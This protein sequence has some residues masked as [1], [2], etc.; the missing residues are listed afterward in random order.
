MAIKSIESLFDAFRMFAERIAN[1]KSTVILEISDANLLR[2]GILHVLDESEGGLSSPGP[3]T[4][5]HP[6]IDR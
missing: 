5:F 1:G 2:L 4:C 6:F 3:R